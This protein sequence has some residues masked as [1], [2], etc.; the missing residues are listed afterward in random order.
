MSET[1]RERCWCCGEVHEETDKAEIARLQAELTAAQEWEEEAKRYSGNADYWRE[2]YYAGADTKPP[3]PRQL[4][5]VV[6]DVFRPGSLIGEDECVLKWLDESG[7]KTFPIRKR[8]PSCDKYEYRVDDADGLYLRAEWLE[9]IRE[10]WTPRKGEAVMATN[11]DGR[12]WEGFYCRRMANGKHHVYV[13]AQLFDEVRPIE[14]E[15]G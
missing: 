13:S 12:D 5:G 11:R 3:R 1:K 4:S 7:G 14:E 2:R 6:R 8:A 10:E 9:D 15:E